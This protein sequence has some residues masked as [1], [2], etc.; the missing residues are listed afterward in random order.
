MMRPTPMS[1]PFVRIF[2]G[3]LVLLAFGVARGEELCRIEVIDEEGWPVPL[4]ELRTV[5]QVRFVTDNAGIIAF[6]LP[7]LMNRE[8]WFDVIGHGYEVPADGFGNRGVRLTPQPSTS[9]R[10]T[11]RRTLPARRLGRLTGAGRLAES[12]RLG[13]V[14]DDPETGILG[15]DSVQNAVYRG[16]LFWFWGDTNLAHYPLG[17]FQTTGATTDIMPGK[18]DAP[19]ISVSY[20]V[21]RDTA[22]RPRG[23]APMPGEGPTWISGV[24]CLRDREGQEHLGCA[25]AK[26]RPPLEA[27]RWGLALW[28]DARQKFESVRIL[29]EKAEEKS[30]QPPPLPQGHAVFWEDEA[31]SKWVLF[32]DPFP[33][34]R[35][36]ATFEAWQDPSQWETLE[37]PQFLWDAEHRNKVVPHRGAIAWHPWRGRWV[38]VFTQQFGKPSAFGELWYA[39]ASRPT[40]PWGKAV[41]IVTH[42]NYTF[43]NPAIHPEFTPE[44]SPSLFFEATYT[45]Q[46]A[47]HASA[48]PRYDYN[49]ILY[50]LDLDDPRLA[51]ARESIAE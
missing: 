16:K 32:G 37:S 17:I 8:V 29:W 18:V 6:D 21:F 7:E 51:P 4:V 31:N 48:T 40:G 42:D 25:Y 47:D 45:R 35:C 27:Y 9:L 43:Y 34:L 20:E 11:V 22:G 5:H 10:V 36:P 1:P 50:R 23:V 2:A 14:V 24:V 44:G 13:L 46:F 30:P 33:S 49:Q 3:F 39:E 15:C 28:N 12:R 38:A 41:K 19:P 26:I